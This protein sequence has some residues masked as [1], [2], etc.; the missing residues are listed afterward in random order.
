MHGILSAIVPLIIALTVLAI[1]WGVFLYVTKGGDEEKRKEGQRFIA[2]GILALF[3]MV[4][5]WGLVNVLDRTF[6][7]D[8]TINMGEIP[9]IPEFKQ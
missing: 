2:Y 8:D 9:K 3:V 7:L 4:S 1:L 5:I 6:N